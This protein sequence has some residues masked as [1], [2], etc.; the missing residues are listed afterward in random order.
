SGAG[1]PE[2]SGV[3]PLTSAE[4]IALLDD[5]YD[6]ANAVGVSH[7]VTATAGGKRAVMQF[8]WDVTTI[9]F[10]KTPYGKIELNVLGG[11]DCDG[12][13]GNVGVRG[14]VYHGSN[15]YWIPGS[16][17]STTSGGSLNNGWGWAGVQY[18]PGQVSALAMNKVDA[19]GV[20]KKFIIANVES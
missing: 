1:A 3:T 16:F 12:I 19:S 2:L 18:I 20:T 10:S 17:F 9:D 11:A 7:S 13:S 14:G 4:K 5:P 8:Q 6:N 15:G